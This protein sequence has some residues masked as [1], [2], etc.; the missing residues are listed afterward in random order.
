M[1]LSQEFWLLEL[2]GGNLAG[3]LS[4]PVDRQRSS[5][6]QQRSG[7]A[8][9]AEITFRDDICASF[10]NY[11]SS[12]HLTLF[13]LGLSIFYVFLFKLTHGETDLCIG[14]INANRYRSELVNMIGMFVS[15]LPYRLEIDSNWT[16]YELVKYVQ[17]K[18]LSILE[19]AHYPL[20]HILDDNRSNQSSVS[21]LETAFDF[22]SVSKDMGHLSLNDVNLEQVSL[23]GLYE[24]AKFDFSLTFVY[25]SSSDDNQLSFSFVCSHDLFEKSSISKIA[26]RFE[27][28]FEQVFQTQSSN[29]PMIDMSSS[30]KKVCLI[31]PDEAKE[32]EL[33]VFHRFENI[34]NEAPA[35]F[36]QARIWLD[37]RTRFDPD[38]PQIAIYNMPFVYRLQPGHTLSTKQ[39]HHALQRT[40]NKHPS[41]HTSLHFDIEKNQ[42]MQRLITH[43][44]KNNNN[45]MFSI[46]ETTY[47]TEEQLNEI[48]HDEKRNP[49]VFNLSQGLVF[50]CHLVYHKRIS[51]NDLLSDKDIL[52]FN[53]HH[54]LF[55][56]PSMNIFHHDLNQAYTTS[57]LLYDD[58]TTLRY[59][60]YAV[61]EQQM[62][63]T[64]ASMF[65]LDSL[66]DCKLD[67]SLSLPFDRYRL[68]NEHR[69]GR[70]TSISFDFGQ[71]LS[72]DFLT[73]AS[74][75]NISLEYLTFAI[76]FIFLFKLTTEQL[77]LCI[78]MN[79][80]NNRYRDELKSVIGL[81]EN[82][83]PLRCQLD[84][85]WSFYQL[86]KH[87]Q[88]ITTNSM[89]YSYYPLQR[90]LDQHP[91]TSKPAFLDISLEFISYKNNNTVMIGDSQLV[92]GSFLFN[93][94]KD[95]ILGIHDFSLSINHDLNLDQLSC[96]MNASLDVF[97]RETVEKISQRFHLILHQLSTS[98][99]ENQINKPIHELSL[100]LSNEQYLMQ[101]LNNTQISFSSPFTCIHHEF[102]YQ[103][104][105]HPQKLAVEL[106]EQSLTYC[107]LLYYVQVLSLTL[108]NEHHVVPGE[109]VCQCV[110]RSLSMVIGIMGIEMAGGVYC[111]LSPRDPQH[112]LHALTQQTQ[113]RLVLIH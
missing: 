86:L 71:D 19:H 59:L 109:I 40:A 82:I 34:V 91:H 33:V 37:E 104:M 1:T 8:S 69:T 77:D 56:F 75:N 68:A 95:E 35:S 31:L 20:Q 108:L 41:L 46:I 4:L 49:Q 45:S 64:G 38:K 96:T 15:T 48:L 12:H 44:H 18:C 17:E 78:A 107:E 14:S 90:I 61:I 62:S 10:L 57:Q 70:G 84:P 93:I 43:D 36:A 24:M 22:I 47:E 5:T 55:D 80:N 2:K 112:R 32:M 54:A 16:F 21:F 6:D 29:T 113:S 28:M 25:N 3:H 63:M 53:F 39:L 66:H 51:S 73:H 88:E 83:I 101:S 85:H 27:Y 60:D 52:I 13:Q 100:L 67:Q 74:S 11:A 81:F 23:N 87:V 103:V 65:W 58:N 30:V 9:T 7:L 76:Y 110:E 72:H 105:K 50:R 94:N 106:D 102:V 26:R 99:I 89:K 92:P 97:N 79:I 111:P 42:L 98:M